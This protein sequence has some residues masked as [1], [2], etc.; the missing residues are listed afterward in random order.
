MGA[1]KN[2]KKEAAKVDDQ[3]I[4]PVIKT[5]EKIVEDPVLL[6]TVALNVFAPGV[7]TII[8]E[9]IGLAG[10]A[11]TVV[12]NVVVNTALNGGDVEKAVISAVLP[13][14]GAEIAS[15]ATSAFVDLGLSDTLAQ[16]AGKATAK[17]VV[18]EVTGQDPAQ[19]FLTSAVT[20]GVKDIAS[21]ID[22][23]QELPKPIQNAVTAGI[24]AELTGGDAGKAATKAL[25]SSGIASLKQTTPTEAAVSTP[26]KPQTDIQPTGLPSIVEAEKPSEPEPA[27]VE[28]VPQDTNPN[29][30]TPA[31][32]VADVGT[33]QQLVSAVEPQQPVQIGPEQEPPT[34]QASATESLTPDL[35]AQMAGWPDAAT[36]DFAERYGIRNVDEAVRAMEASKNP[37]LPSVVPEPAVTTPV[38]PAPEI[39]EA[40][41]PAL[42]EDAKA[43]EPEKQ[44]EVEQVPTVTETK[45][46][47][48]GLP[49]VM[50]PAQ[51][52]MAQS[53]ADLYTNFTP[54]QLKAL[55]YLQ[56]QEP[57]AEEP[58]KQTD[59]TEIAPANI[60]QSQPTQPV[61]VIAEKTQDQMTPEDWKALYALPS[62]DP[63]TG[64]TKVGADQN[65]Y[66]VQDF[67]ASANQNMDSFNQT[68][69]DIYDNG[70]TTSQWAP[71]DDGTKTMVHDDGSTVT[72]D[73]NS[74]IVN[75]TPATDTAP[76]T[77]PKPTTPKPA[78]SGPTNAPAKTNTSQNLIS[79]AIPAIV[80]AGGVAALNANSDGTPEQQAAARKIL[81]M[82]WNQQ[83]VLAPKGG[84]AYGQQYLNPK[85]TEVQAAQGG[86]MSLA[87]GGML[88]S[89]SDGGRLLRGPG[90][91]MSDNIPASISDK[92]PARLADGEF[93]IPADVV[94]HL[95]NG[96]T[97]AGSRV[98]YEMLNRVRKARTG[99]PK[100]GK[101]INATKFMPK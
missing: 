21:N 100:Q 101:Q 9:A 89:Y 79:A 85:F 58:A 5:V 32:K 18:A 65:L 92:Q 64:E 2:L 6:A 67:G 71:N 25:V 26:V 36:Q 63:V 31:P 90:D 88:G 74:N 41:L 86:L 87:G 51:T 46:T 82:D 14:A 3:I 1:W 69:Q 20:S 72:I 93:V 43:N 30:E 4:Q 66:P 60:G 47:E 10:T 37:A 27:K 81:R 40:G 91:G 62:T 59:V 94:S 70:G 50:E 11:A 15:A 99:N 77:T 16:A 76:V 53:Q 19:A 17:A 44:T 73:E 95:G 29:K 52:P 49:S 57:V 28:Q 23:F 83:D 33:D 38:E 96:S 8:G 13:V 55:Q 54:D 22:A 97:E 48:P 42:V 24:T 98:L 84:I 78:T 12:G 39:K 35:Q 56:D 7:G 75:V 68:L 61:D 80:A 45:P 34:Y